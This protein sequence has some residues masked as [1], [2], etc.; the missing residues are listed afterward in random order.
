MPGTAI[1]FNPNITSFFVFLVVIVILNLGILTAFRMQGNPQHLKVPNLQAL[2]TWR[3]KT[4]RLLMWLYFDRKIVKAPTTLQEQDETVMSV[5][6]SI[7]IDTNPLGRE[8]SALGTAALRPVD[9]ETNL[10]SRSR[11]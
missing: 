1:P 9:L 10:R 7:D 6:S 2:G 5:S 8:G 4:R 3:E 11:R